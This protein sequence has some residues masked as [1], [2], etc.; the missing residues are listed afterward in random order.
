V[1]PPLAVQ[2]REGVSVADRD[3]LTEELCRARAE[4]E[5]QCE[6]KCNET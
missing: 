4:R 2:Q 3:D 6:C 1:L 5:Q